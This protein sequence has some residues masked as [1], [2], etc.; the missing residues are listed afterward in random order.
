MNATASA[1]VETAPL[2]VKDEKNV[3][4]EL[5]LVDIKGDIKTLGKEI[6]PGV[7]SLVKEADPALVKQADD[8]VELLLGEKHD[9]GQKRI[10][11]D[12]L[13]LRTQEEAARRSAMLKEPMRTLYR[14]SHKGEGKTVGDGLVDL[15]QRMLDLDPVKFGLS[16]KN[17]QTLLGRTKIGKIIDR[18]WTKAQSMETVIDTIVKSIDEGA[19]RLRR[20]NE[21]YAEDQEAMREATVKLKQV[22]QMAMLIDESLQKKLSDGSIT[23]QEQI[24]FIQ[25]EL[26]FP[27][28]KRIM[29]LQQTLLANQQAIMTSEIMVN[30][31]RE[32]IRGTNDA[33]NVSVVQLQNVLAL[34][35]GLYHQ[36]DQLTKLNELNK[37]TEHFMSFGSEL[38]DSQATQVNQMASQA[39]ISIET[40]EKCMANIHSAFDKI[41]TFRREALPQ[42]AESVVRMDK[43][44]NFNE[45]EIK[46]REKGKEARAQLVIDVA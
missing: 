46:K 32:L 22:I 16:V 36:R 23:D 26:L 17:L 13:G 29:S 28:R 20:D 39:M 10:A 15:K 40:L 7:K 8:F 2:A 38:L 6:D 9:R 24:K 33:K 35:V 34:I 14:N 21:T 12:Q 30:T 3:A 25:Q 11:V 31:N 41:D 45:K 43:M 5:K 42:M 37:T 27:V 1:A 19:E 4:D 18:Y 44:I